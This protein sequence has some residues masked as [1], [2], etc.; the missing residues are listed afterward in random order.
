MA[1]FY[2]HIKGCGAKTTGDGKNSD[3]WTWIKWA[4][5]ESLQEI[6]AD[7]RWLPSIKLNRTNL[8]S[9]EPSVDAG[10]IIGDTFIK[11]R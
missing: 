2:N 11:I 10:K 3:L 4:D 6:T 7:V 9:G 1:I 5:N 8:T